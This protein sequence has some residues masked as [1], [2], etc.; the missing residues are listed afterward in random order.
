[1]GKNQQRLQ[2]TAD[3]LLSQ[4]AYKQWRITGTHSD[5][6]ARIEWNG[7]M[8]KLVSGKGDNK[9]QQQPQNGTEPWEVKNFFQGNRQ[10]N[11]QQQQIYQN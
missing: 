2:E 1:M 11:S 9:Y 4:P 10:V 6:S 3:C 5:L 7:I 8:N